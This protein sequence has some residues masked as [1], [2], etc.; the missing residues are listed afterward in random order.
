MGHVS[1]FMC[2]VFIV[3]CFKI[4]SVR[5]GLEIVTMQVAFM[6]LEI[7]TVSVLLCKFRFIF[8]FKLHPLKITVSRQV[9]F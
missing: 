2:L 7:L 3:K 8:S 9:Y 5:F 1:D 6:L 4:Y